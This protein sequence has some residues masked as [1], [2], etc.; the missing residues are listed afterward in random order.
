MLKKFVEL[1]HAYLPIPLTLFKFICNVKN[2]YFRYLILKYANIC[3]FYDID[4]F[5]KNYY[6]TT[7]RS[8]YWHYLTQPY[9][10]NKDYKKLKTIENQFPG[11]FENKVIN[12]GCGL[13]LVHKKFIIKDLTL[14]DTN[15]FV[16]KEIKKNF[17]ELNVIELDVN[18]TKNMRYNTILFSNGVLM[19][20]DKNE[21]LNFFSNNYF[22]NIIIFNEGSDNQKDVKIGKGIMHNFKNIFSE[23]EYLKKHKQYKVYSKSENSI[24]DI[25]IVSQINRCE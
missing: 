12:V 14:L 24:F 2:K 19:Y 16:I 4:K 1:Q 3:V 17:P 7:K 20:F 25:F 5:N 23:I 15:R 13:G 22:E 11:I 18:E 6:W 10:A 8:L 9:S 21:I